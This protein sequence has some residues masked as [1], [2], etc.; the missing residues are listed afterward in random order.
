M[1]VA[2]KP[3][4][5]LRGI[6]SSFYGNLIHG[7]NNSLAKACANHPECKGFR[8][9]SQLGFGYLCN[10]LK[11]KQD[12]HTIDK[13]EIDDWQLCSFWPGMVKHCMLSQK[14]H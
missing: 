12:V 3:Y 4:S 9:S 10:N 13:K 14:I 6:C 5:C 11:V 2:V 1:N 7:T 8:Y